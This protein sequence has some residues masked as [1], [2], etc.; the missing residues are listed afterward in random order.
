MSRS[1]GI[2]LLIPLLLLELHVDHRCSNNSNIKGK[3]LSSRD[4]GGG[5]L[6]IEHKEEEEEEER[7]MR[8]KLGSTRWYLGGRQGVFLSS[9][10]CSKGGGEVD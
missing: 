8:R 10:R 5:T 3:L 2:D 1:R 6:G 7:N 4:R 9:N